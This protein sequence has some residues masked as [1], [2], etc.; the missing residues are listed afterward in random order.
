MSEAF[1]TVSITSLCTSRST[2]RAQSNEASFS[3]PL[4]FIDV[5]RQ[6][7]TKLEILE[8]SIID[9]WWN[10]DGNR[11]NSLGRLDRWHQI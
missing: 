11:T 1:Q 9:D 8:E 3:T 2:L 5:T 4:K 6:T 10:V 7:K